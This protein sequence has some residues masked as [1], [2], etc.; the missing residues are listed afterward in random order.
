MSPKALKL[1][2]SPRSALQIGAFFRGGGF[3]A[4]PG[5]QALG[6]LTAETFFFSAAAILASLLLGPLDMAVPVTIQLG[7]LTAAVVVFGLPHGALDPWIARQA[8]VYR[9]ASGL[10]AFNLAYLSLAGLVLLIWW[11]SP[12]VALA[13]FLLLSAFHFSGDW[14][15]H[16][17]PWQRVVAALALLSMP[18]V[19]DPQSVEAIF[20]ALS[21]SAAASLAHGLHIMGYV[22]VAALLVVL[23]SALVQRQYVAVV[24]LAILLLLAASVP[25][26]VY[27]TIY[28]CLLHS[29]RHM[30]S[31]LSEAANQPRS[32]LLINASIYTFATLAIAALI[33]L[34]LLPRIDMTQLILQLVFIGLAALTVPHMLLML[35]AKPGHRAQRQGQ[36]PIRSTNPKG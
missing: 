3:A 28:F 8:G 31:T 22:A 21:G 35:L 9:G 17:A 1:A 30:R 14:Q 23:A 5:R 32:A 4:T 33:A 24:E 16:M 11:V 26:L 7:L 36:G 10:I 34:Y 6:D 18:A 2:F 27:F 20:I 25:P 19:F 15:L 13:L 12:V 29:P